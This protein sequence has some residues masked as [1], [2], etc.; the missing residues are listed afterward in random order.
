M[1]EQN[2][3]SSGGIGV[4]CS[5]GSSACYPRSGLKRSTLVKYRKSPLMETGDGVEGYANGQPF[6]MHSA[7]CIGG[8]DYGCNHRGFEIADDAAKV[9]YEIY[10]S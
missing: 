6:Y 7:K 5:A 3:V 2:K 4:L 1:S 9:D 10:N 8:C